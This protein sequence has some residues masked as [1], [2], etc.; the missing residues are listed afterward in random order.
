MLASFAERN[1]RLLWTGTVVTQVGQWMQQVAIGWLVLELTD[2]ASF[3]G[4]VGLRAAF[5]C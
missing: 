2:S 5:R 1:Y 3:L 4:I